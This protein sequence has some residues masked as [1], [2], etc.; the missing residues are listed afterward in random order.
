MR[1]RAQPGGKALVTDRPYLETKEH[2]GGFL[3]NRS[4]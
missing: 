4:L 1:E 2:M 3:D